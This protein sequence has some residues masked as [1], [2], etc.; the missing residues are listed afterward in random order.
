VSDDVDVANDQAEQRLSILIKRAS[1][2]LQKG[3]PGDCDLCGEWS[4]RL[5]EAV[6]APCRDRYK[7]R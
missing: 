6:C 1:K 2:P 5:I 7:L 4:G 3:S